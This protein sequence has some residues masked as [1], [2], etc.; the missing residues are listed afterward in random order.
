MR[1]EECVNRDLERVEG[2]RRTKA[3]H[4]RN[5][6]LVRENALVERSAEERLHDKKSTVTM[7]NLTL[8]DR[9][10]MLTT[11]STNLRKVA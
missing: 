3:K 5:W 6:G 1:W 9:D 10:N 2:E 4:S 7:A 8:D 11:G